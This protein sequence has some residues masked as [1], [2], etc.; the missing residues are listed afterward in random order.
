M[1][2]KITIHLDNFKIKFQRKMLL[3]DHF[4]LL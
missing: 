1:K 4:A 2:V 3:L